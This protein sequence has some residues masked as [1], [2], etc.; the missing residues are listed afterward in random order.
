MKSPLCFVVEPANG[1]LY[2]NVR[3]NGL[4][5]SASKE[6]HTTTARFATVIST[7]IGYNG[8]IQE[9]DSVMVHHNTFRKYFNMK[10]KEVYGPAHFRDN[11][12]L[13]E[14]VYMYKHDGKFYCPAPYCMVRP[15]KNENADDIKTTNALLL[16]V[17]EL[18][19]GNE[20]LRALG[21][22]DGDIVGFTQDAEYEF[23]VND[24]IL[25]RMFTRNIY[26]VKK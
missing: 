22:N 16:Q 1:R 23:R 15:I 24:E 26:G 10:G 17:G 11:T 9:G 2:D 25:Y 7:P 3:E 6:D 5:V 20:E 14:D 18:V 21:V 8:P 13:V 19:Y 4:I 12:F